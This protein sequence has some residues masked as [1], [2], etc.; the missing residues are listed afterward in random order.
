MT[1]DIGGG[2][3]SVFA[4]EAAAATDPLLDCLLALAAH[5]DRS[6]S[7]DVVTAGLPLVDGKLTPASFARAAERAGFDSKIV[8][9]PL[10]RL[11]PVAMPVILLLKDEDACVVVELLPRRRAA[12]LDPVTGNVTR[13]KLRSLNTVYTG[14][15][16]L[17]KPTLRLGLRGPESGQLYRGHWFWGAVRRLWPSYL[18]VIV[19]AAIIN[20]LALAAPLF[21]MNV[22]DRVLPNKALPTLWVLAAGIGL[23]IVFD[24]I[25]KSLRGWL[26]D[27]AGRRADVLLS[28]RIYEHVLALKL[29]HRPATTGGFASQLREF[30]QVREF[31]TSGTLATIT[32][33]AFFGLFI[34]VIYQ[35][36]GP[37]AY[38][39]ATG[40]AIVFLV[41][42]IL[43]IP[44]RRAAKETQSETAYRHSLLVESVGALETIKAIRAE[45]YLQRIWERLVGRTARTLE[46]TRRIQSTILHLTSTVQQLVTV[47]VI[48][49]GAYLFDA[50]DVS[51][52]AIIA[53]VILAGRAVAP[54]GQF[55]TLVARSQQSFAALRTL[56]TIMNLPSERPDGKAFVAQPINDGKIEFKSV[57]FS[58]PNAPNPAL[59]DMSLTIEPGE[60]VGI[61]G[62]IGSGKTT[63]G[64]LLCGMYDAQ[65]GAV[66]IDDIDIRQFHPYEV[67]REIGVVTQDADLFYG[68]VRE[69]IVMGHP[70]ASDEELVEACR[71][72]GVDDFVMKHP[73]GL[74]MPVGERGALL[75]GGQRQAVA[76]ARVFLLKPRVVF[77]DEP[78]GSMDLQSERILIGHLQALADSG[79]TLIVS[80]HRHSMLD[81]VDRLV[82]LSNGKVAANGPKQKVLDALR[83]SSAKG[84]SKA[85]PKVMP[86]R[87]QS[88]I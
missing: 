75:S 66:L 33:V 3:D 29:N 49:V 37:I 23:A 77:L 68:T 42:L 20:V 59:N 69:N 61:I 56:N 79:Q 30:D 15:A 21:I 24:F 70:E 36:G 25:L 50:G 16:I 84:G 55:A 64:R 63:I 1:E 17:L 73:S 44:L 67:R 87:Q 60:R 41:G 10:S 57:V 83:A 39:P 58:Y 6:V 26:T 4:L 31:F 65:D 28:G 72:A 12:V 9:R 74:D 62:K 22:Y 46:K 86:V 40:A 18:Q 45:G 82:V 71:L 35:V 52:G 47:S 11:N 34:F 43:H 13:I 54:F 76:L 8:K 85:V 7:A 53:C 80:T 78:S 48:I 88:S 32:D 14:V 38:V 2:Q 19:A 27:A 81:L 51:M 5:H